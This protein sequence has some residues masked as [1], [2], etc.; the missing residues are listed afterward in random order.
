MFFL[1]MPL[2]FSWPPFLGYS[3]GKSLFSMNFIT[4]TDNWLVPTDA[5]YH[6]LNVNEFS[7]LAHLGLGLDSLYLILIAYF[8]FIFLFP[9]KNSLCQWYQ[10]LRVPLIFPGQVPSQK[11]YWSLP[12]VQWKEIFFRYSWRHC[13]SAG[14]GSRSGYWFPRPLSSQ[15]GSSNMV[16][17]EKDKS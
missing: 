12:E 2:F 14:W 5:L 6:V 10:K 8:A 1:L 16:Q 4:N 3:F 15:L 7:V 9:H 11:D 17:T 13:W